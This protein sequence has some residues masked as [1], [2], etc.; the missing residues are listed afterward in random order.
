[1]LEELLHWSERLSFI[2]DQISL[3]Q[4]LI[5][6]A[7]PR[8]CTWTQ[9]VQIDSLDIFIVSVCSLF[10]SALQWCSFVYFILIITAL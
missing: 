4:F 6:R 2:V 8:T 10:L 5:P 7:L 3:P 1:M 9:P